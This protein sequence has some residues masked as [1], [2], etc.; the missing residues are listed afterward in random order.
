M[1]YSAALP[2]YTR[3]SSATRKQFQRFQHLLPVSQGHNLAF[4]VFRVPYSLDSSSSSVHPRMKLTTAQAWRAFQS[5]RQAT[6]PFPTLPHPTLHLIDA[7]SARTKRSG[8]DRP[9][10]YPYALQ[11]APFLN[12]QPCTLNPI[13]STPT[14]V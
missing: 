3:G 5:W 11:P 1:K 2:A 10:L 8:T 4:T 12:P 7:G 13:P 14:S 9:Q 6:G